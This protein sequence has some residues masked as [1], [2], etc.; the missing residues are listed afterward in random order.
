MGI[1]MLGT[2]V[3][4][5]TIQSII[6]ALQWERNRNAHL[7]PN[8]PEAKIGLRSDDRI[9]KIEA[10]SKH[11][12][13]FRTLLSQTRKAAGTSEGRCFVLMQ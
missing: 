6:N 8:D 4:H 1:E 10:A 11:N 2:T 12:K 7:Y 3:G 5:S 13:P 9:K